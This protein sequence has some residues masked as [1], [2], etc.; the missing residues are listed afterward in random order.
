MNFGTSNAE[1]GIVS[2]RVANRAAVFCVKVVNDLEKGC[3][4]V[5]KIGVLLESVPQ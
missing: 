2:G 4:V 3:D 5:Q 1:T